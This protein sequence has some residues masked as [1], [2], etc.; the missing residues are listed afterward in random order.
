MTIAR[1]H[2][3]KVPQQN[4][5]DTFSPTEGQPFPFR[6]LSDGPTI[7]KAILKH[8]NLCPGSKLLWGIIRHWSKVNATCFA[9]TVRFAEAL[10]VSVD[11][12]KRYKRE[13]VRERLLMVRERPGSTLA[14]QLLW[15][16]CFLDLDETEEPHKRTPQGGAYM[17]GGR[18]INAPPISNTSRLY[19]PT[20]EVLSSSE[21]FEGSKPPSDDDLKTGSKK[22]SAASHKAWQTSNARAVEKYIEQQGSIE[23]PILA[24]MIEATGAAPPDTELTLRI[25]NEL[26]RTHRTLEDFGKQ[27]ETRVARLSQPPGPGFFLK[28][29]R[30][31]C[32]GA[33]D[34]LPHQIR[35]P[36]PQTKTP[37]VCDFCEFSFTV[38]GQCAVTVEGEILSNAEALAMDKTGELVIHQTTRCPVCGPSNVRVSP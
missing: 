5:W 15:H 9:R 30:D 24:A 22:R 16:P 3:Q 33:L 13:L 23:V 38:G 25:V 21:R 7:L 2:P 4:R 1:S 32:A 11:Q 31:F 27:M 28:L 34:R 37:G 18:D 26:H 19:K 6:K 35:I 12:I 14:L 8:P 10:N 29:A 17:Q 36:K 20:R